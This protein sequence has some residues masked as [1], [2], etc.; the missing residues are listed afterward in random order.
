[1]LIITVVALLA[2]WGISSLEGRLLRWRPPSAADAAHGV[3]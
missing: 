2:E 1:M 3:V